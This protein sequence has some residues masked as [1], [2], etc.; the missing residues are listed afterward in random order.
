MLLTQSQ[1]Q[2][3][4]PG[5]SDVFQ[6]EEEEEQ[7]GDEPQS[8][9]HRERINQE[10]Y[11]SQGPP[12]SL[13]T[14]PGSGLAPP[15]DRSA[16]VRARARTSVCPAL[17]GGGQALCV[18]T[19]SPRGVPAIGHPAWAAPRTAPAQPCYGHD[20]P[21]LSEHHPTGVLH[22]PPTSPPAATWASPPHL[23]PGRPWLDG[24]PHCPKGCQARPDSNAATL[25]ATEGTS[26]MCPFLR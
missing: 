19:P 26:Q 8:K 17:C 5:G 7:E 18:C 4:L 10:A 25:L 9:A 22:Q 6:K 20:H 13:T 24:W 2:G 14:P 12:V 21:G 11:S 3:G 15:W 23:V 1:I 16:T